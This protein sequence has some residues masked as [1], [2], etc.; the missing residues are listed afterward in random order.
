[1]ELREKFMLK[2]ICLT[3]RHGTYYTNHKEKRI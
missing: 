3:M 1:M 2:K